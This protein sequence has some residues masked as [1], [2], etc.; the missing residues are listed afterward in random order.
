MNKMKNIL[1][2]IGFVL[3]TLSAMLIISALYYIV[4]K[5]FEIVKIF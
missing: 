4:E 1:K 2:T 5:I 3:L